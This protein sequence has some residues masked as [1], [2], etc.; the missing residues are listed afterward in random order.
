[1]K[2]KRM[3]TALMAAAVATGGLVAGAAAYGSHHVPAMNNST[4]SITALAVSA[5][6]SLGIG[7]VWYDM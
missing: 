7:E 4:A 2:V 6:T 3:L 5:T 1:M